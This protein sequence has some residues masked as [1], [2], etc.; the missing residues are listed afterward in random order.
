MVPNRVLRCRYLQIRQQRQG[1]RP[2]AM[3]S[4]ILPRKRTHEWYEARYFQGE[5]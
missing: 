4:V 3:H 1:V 2:H 5:P